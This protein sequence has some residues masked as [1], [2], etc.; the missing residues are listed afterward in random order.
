MADLVSYVKRLN[1]IGIT[2]L[3]CNNQMPYILTLYAHF[4]LFK[5]IYVQIVENKRAWKGGKG[6]KGRIT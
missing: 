4:Y 6:G 5:I 2:L 1:M 3:H